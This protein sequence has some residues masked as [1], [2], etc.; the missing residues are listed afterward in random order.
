MAEAASTAGAKGYPV[1][2]NLV[3]KVY[4]GNVTSKIAIREW[5]PIESCGQRADNLDEH[6]EKDWKVKVEYR[7][8]DRKS[9]VYECW[10]ET[11]ATQT[12]LGSGEK[13][14][15]EIVLGGNRRSEH[16][17]AILIGDPPYMG[18]EFVPDHTE[19]SD[20]EANLSVNITIDVR[21]DAP[22]IAR[23]MGHRSDLMIAVVKKKGDEWEYLDGFPQIYRNVL[24]FCVPEFK[25]STAG[26][27]R[28]ILID[29]AHKNSDREDIK[30]AISGIMRDKNGN[31]AEGK[32][33]GARTCVKDWQTV[34]AP[35]EGSSDTDPP[36]MNV[37]RTEIQS[38]DIC[39]LFRKGDGARKI[40]TVIGIDFSGSTKSAAD[41]V[42][43][44]GDKKRPQTLYEGA[45]LAISEKMRLYS[46]DRN[47]ELWALCGRV[48]G[49]YRPSYRMEDEK[50]DVLEMYRKT[51]AD[52]VQFSG[53]SG[54]A[55]FLRPLVVSARENKKDEDFLTIFILTDGGMVDLDKMIET[56]NEH[57]DAPD[58]TPKILLVI[59]GICSAD[60]EWKRN[61]LER[62]LRRSR[63]SAVAYVE[64]KEEYI[65]YPRGFSHVFDVVVERFRNYALAQNGTRERD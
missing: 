65:M 51:K 40:R 38:S 23:W 44:N 31:N 10:E 58:V 9:L 33:A 6:S 60:T 35:R 25:T 7:F 32:N 21:K 13:T 12:L 18:V 37:Q 45:L 43:Y 29:L 41:N 8:S 54:F 22:K 34:K 27:V 46:R 4:Q 36:V 28:C 55:A 57:T 19:R 59:V 42:I 61:A 3:F 50:M 17:D 16:G 49:E 47:V 64:Y 30:K 56:L 39:S 15:D 62:S 26:D 2:G 5:S 24:R 53:P 52:T 20:D 11:G 14:I 48:S 1:E 63:V